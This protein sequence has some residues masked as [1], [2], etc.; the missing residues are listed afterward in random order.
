MG[1]FL[2]D[3]DTATA[4]RHAE[5]SLALATQLDDRYG[6]AL[7]LDTLARVAAHDSDYAR[8]RP[9]LERALVLARRLEHR[10]VMYGA[11]IVLGRVALAAGD[12]Q[13][14]NRLLVEALVLANEAGDSWYIADALE[15][16]GGSVVV[17]QPERTVRLAG[18][19]AGLRQRL[20]FT[21][22]AIDRDWIVQRLEA[23][24]SILG[25]PPYVAAWKEGISRSVDEAVQYALT[26]QAPHATARSGAAHRAGLDHES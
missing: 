22:S 8:A 20:G 3:G 6:T 23:A 4:A 11:L 12:A 26:D 2:W 17:S 24:H 9:L 1:V 7:S 16:I 19:A 15:A 5:D 18:A 10:Q 13:E 21:A 14:A 25:E